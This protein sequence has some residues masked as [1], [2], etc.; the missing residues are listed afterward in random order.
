MMKKFYGKSPVL[1]L[2]D[3]RV[4]PKNASLT[5]EEQKKKQIRKLINE[6]L[7]AQHPVGENYS[8]WDAIVA[9]RDYIL[10]SSFLRITKRNYLSRMQKLIECAV[11]NPALKLS[12]VNESWLKECLDK[13]DEISL[14]SKVSRIGKQQLLRETQLRKPETNV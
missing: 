7:K 5:D 12:T 9:W 11:I 14:G 2:E 10:S 1:E 4:I 6:K 3:T 13:I 8:I